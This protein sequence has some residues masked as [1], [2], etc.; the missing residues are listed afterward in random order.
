VLAARDGAQY[1]AAMRPLRDPRLLRATWIILGVIGWAGILWVGAMLASLDPPR[2]GD[3]LRLLVDA[4]RRLLD[5]ESLYSSVPASG[6]LE[7]EG[8]FYSYPPP[9]AQAL[10][11]VSGLPLEL[12][13]VL[14]GAGSVAGL[15]L[16]AGRLGRP[17]GGLILPTLALAPFTFPF[18]VALL[19]G[20]L[21]AWFPLAFGLLLVGVLGGS[22]R[23]T[24]A[25]GAALAV[26]SVAKLHPATLVLWLVARA[27]RERRPTPEFLAASAA[28]VAGLGIIAAS[29][30]L[31]GV[32]PWNDYLVF[33]RSGAATSDLASPLNI[34]PASQL[35]LLLGL[36]DGQVR[37]VQVVV[38]L[39]VL[40]V[41]IAAGWRVRDPVLSIGLATT[42]SLVA[43]PVTWVHYPVALI[44]VAIAAAARSRAGDGQLVGGLVGAAIV[45][46]AFAVLVP[47]VIWIAVAIVLAAAYASRPVPTVRRRSPD[48]LLQSHHRLAFPRRGGLPRGGPR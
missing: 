42:A 2:A 27:A 16:V 1:H 7:A 19:F 15:V 10:G 3:D 29:L 22:R 5:G 8:L 35:A 46:A 28:L 21:N 12:L 20:N 39:A 30:V 37:S 6:S 25:G 4:A 40:G 23:E 11:P 13:L 26:V 44:P 36:E 48:A 43:L 34:G 9:V 31:D 41:S 32:A 24:L 18:A 45:V 14:W 47:V 38:F 33:L 17:A